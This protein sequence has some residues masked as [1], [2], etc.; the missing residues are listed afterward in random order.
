M[1]GDGLPEIAYGATRSSRRR[2]ARSRSRAP[3]ATA[4][5]GTS[6]PGALHVRRSRRP[7]DNHLELLAG[8]TAYRSDG[9]VLWQNS[10]VRDGFPGVGDFDKTASP[11]RSLVGGGKVWILERR[12]RRD[13]RS[14]RSRSPAPAPAARP[15]SP[16]STATASPRSAS[17]M[18]T[19]YSV[20][21]PTITNN[22]ITGIDVLWKSAA[23]TTSQLVGHRLDGVRLRGRRQGRGH[24]RRRVL[25][26]GL[27][28]HD[29]RRALRGAAHV[30]HGDRGLAGR[31]RRRR[32]PRRD[33]HGRNG[34][35]PATPVE[36]HTARARQAGDGQR[37]DWTPGAAPNTSYRGLVAFG[38]TARLVGRHAHALE[39]AHLPRDQH[40]RRPRHARAPRRTSTDRSPRSRRRTGRCR[41]STT[42]ARTCRTRASSTRPTRSSRSRSIASTPVVAHVSV[43]NIGLASLPAGVD[44]DVFVTPG[45]TLVGTR[46]DDASRS[47]RDRRR[48]S[49]SRSPRR[50]TRARISTRRS[51]STRKT[52]RSTSATTRTTRA[53]PSN[54]RA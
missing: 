49:T 11:R 19:F 27:R 35:D 45:D 54:R 16:T 5:G 30:V 20:L 29:R 28:R 32:R 40:L 46:D 47:S 38:D 13:R 31:R 18:A 4:S 2:A 41:G 17:R 37:P 10:S 52:R 48:R 9:T 15:R 50:P 44:V 51:T 22:A 23:T 36:L 34:A 25:P 12:D 24:L 8:N 43:R 14:A 3:A 39:R 1:D 21:K 6:R 42:S 26:L 7:N 53:P 33:A